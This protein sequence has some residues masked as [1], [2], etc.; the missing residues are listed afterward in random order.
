MA[1]FKEVCKQWRR[2]CKAFNEC[3]GNCVDLCA[4]AHNPVC[5]DLTQATDKDLENAEAVIMEWA[6][7][8][9]EPVCPTWAEYLMHVYQDVSYARILGETIP[10]DIAEKLGVAPKVVGQ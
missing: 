8:N 7:E 5:G 10:A 2:M 6:N 1:E 9:P 3:D 4:L